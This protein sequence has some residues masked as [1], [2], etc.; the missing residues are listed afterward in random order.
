MAVGRHIGNRKEEVY[1]PRDQNASQG[2]WIESIGNVFERKAALREVY[3]DY[4]QEIRKLSVEGKTL[5]VG[6][7]GGNLGD[8]FDDIILTDIVPSPWI[9]IAADAQKLP[10][11]DSSFANIIA[12]DVLHHIEWP[13][14][15]L[16]EASRLL[17]PGGK[18]I[19]LEPAITAGSWFFYK[20]Y[21]VE[22]TDMRVDPLE[23]GTV[24]ALRDAR[25]ANQAIATLLQGK[26]NSKLKAALPEFEQ[27]DFRHLTLLAWPLSGAFKPWSLIPHWAVQPILSLKRLL[28]PFVGRFLSFR[29]M[30]SFTRR[31][32]S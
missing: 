9:N 30:L 3:Q 20:F 22:E 18:L 26:Y 25:L 23:K 5:E 2:E 15:F 1:D 32:N 17:E 21:Y 13:I 31:G 29:L 11:R 28:L 24:D 27:F 8:F 6:S 12:I 19:L 7:A 16:K 4:Y 14:Y 10:F